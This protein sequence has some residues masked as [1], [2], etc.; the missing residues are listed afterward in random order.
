MVIGF[1]YG[2]LNFTLTVALYC[3][4]VHFFFI[5]IYHTI[6]NKLQGIKIK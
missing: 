3:N 5:I 6:L 2:L 4:K 1:Y